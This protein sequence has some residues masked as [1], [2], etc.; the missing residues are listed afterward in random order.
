MF[1]NVIIAVSDEESA[2]DALALGETLTSPGAALMLVHVEQGGG[3]RET[4][5]EPPA[6]LVSLSDGP[7]GAEHP[8]VVV[9]APSPAAGLH[10]AA[11]RGG[12]DLLVIGAPRHRVLGRAHTEAIMRDAP[13]AVAVAPRGF[14]GRPTA[15]QRIGVG[16]DGSLA[17]DAA[18]ATARRLAAER[19]ATVSALEVVTPRPLR[20]PLNA[21]NEID[22]RLAAGRRRLAGLAGVDTSVEYGLPDEALARYGASVDL[23]VLGPHD[24]GVQRASL[25]QRLARRPPCPLLVLATPSGP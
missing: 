23:L 7:G 1:D 17:S 14:A 20:D 21:S 22:D 9:G 24:H 15:L 4:P 12:A 8:L 18:L 19:E 10:D 6:P 11:S 5:Q 3:D 13:C 16:Y 25:A 2:L